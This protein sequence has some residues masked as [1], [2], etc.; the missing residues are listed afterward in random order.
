MKIWLC[1]NENLSTAIV[2]LQLI[3][4]EKFTVNGV[5]RARRN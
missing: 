5:L 3:Q 2:S 4:E 1:H